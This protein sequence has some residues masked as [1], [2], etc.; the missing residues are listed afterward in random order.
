MFGENRL[1]DYVDYSK[2]RKTVTITRN[3][4]KFENKYNEGRYYGVSNEKIVSSGQGD[5]LIF[6][7]EINDENFKSSV[8]ATLTRNGL[9]VIKQGIKIKLYKALP[10]KKQTFE[11]MF[12]DTNYNVKN[13]M[14][15]KKRIVGLT[16]YYKSAQESLMPRFN[17]MNNYHIVKVI[18]SEYQFSVYEPAR[19][20]ERK[21]EKNSGK[22]GGKQGTDISSSTYK[23][24]S[25][26]YCNFAMPV[27]PGRPVP[28]KKFIN[29]QEEKD[30]KKE[31]EDEIPDEIDDDELVDLKG[32]NSYNEK[33]NETINFLSKNQELLL[34]YR[35][36]VY[37]PKFLSILENILDPSH[38][39]LHLVYSQFRKLEGIGI[40]KLVLEANGFVQFKV[41]KNSTGIWDLNM[42]TEDIGKPAFVLYTGTETAEEKEVVRNIYNG[43]WDS[44]SPI[45]AKLQ[46]VSPNNNLGEIIKVFMITSSGSEG[47]TLKNTRY[48]HIMEPY[49]NPA[50]IEQVI[51]RARRICSHT[52]LPEDLQTVDVFIYLMVL[53]QAEIESS[54]EL[55]KYDKSK[56]KYSF[57]RTG[58]YYKDDKNGST[59]YFTTD[60][61][62]YE[63]MTIKEQISSNFLQ[64][65]KESS[66]DCSIYAT[67]GNKEK[68]NCI[69]FPGAN[70]TDYTYLPDITHEEADKEGNINKK[71]V[72]LSAVKT[73][74]NDT[75]YALEWTNE[76][77]TEGKL[78]DYDSWKRKIPVHLFNL[79]ILPDGRKKIT[80]VIH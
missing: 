27:P 47:I 31:T 36:E 43:K 22:K 67:V 55:K 33:V 76:E 63:I 60:Q 45:T 14:L 77:H 29:I 40:F 71:V 6:R 9:N 30:E 56:L 13:L 66:I 75:D 41:R 28:D 21:K 1:V 12:I 39:G 8:I 17:K 80:R 51:G 54:I 20:D 2:E 73:T 65:I 3:P 18:M 50:R 19:V 46:R 34:P 52:D 68:L 72:K 4:Y 23:I 78:Y 57:D 59:L 62:L 38:I 61:T 24:F 53:T 74:Y 10:D 5:K 25:R 69:Q 37:S 32:D 42:P 11:N 64:A 26:L 70:S 15:F 35:L 48:V 58:Q 49:W 44:N 79:K 7:E 16:S